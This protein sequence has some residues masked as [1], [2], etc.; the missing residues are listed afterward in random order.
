[1]IISCPQCTTRLQLD[2]AKVPARAFTVRCPKCQ[3][4]I[5]GQPPAAGEQPPPPLPQQQSALG[6]GSA[7]ALENARYKPAAPAPALNVGAEAA[8]AD[9]ELTSAG[10][11]QPAG[12][13]Q[14]AGSD[15]VARLLVELLQR[16]ASSAGAGVPQ[17]VAERLAWERPRALVCV[18]PERREAV[19]QKLAGASYEVFIAADTTQAVERMREERMSVVVLEPE[20]DPVEQGAAFVTREVN[21]L[22]P[23]DRRRLV[24]VHL[25]PTARTLDPH[26]AFIANVNLVVNASDVEQ[27]PRALERTTRDLNELYRDFNQALGVA[28]L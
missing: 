1:M 26:A 9:G 6:V 8:G 17:K 5:N 27:L 22:R 25:S 14:A 15:D 7:P 20:F 23:A 10:V 11:S 24:F 19:A 18:S 2:D 12:A 3:N 28:A 16:A 4:V 13:P 21:T